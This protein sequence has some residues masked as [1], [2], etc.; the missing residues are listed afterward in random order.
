MD[1]ATLKKKLIAE[2]KNLEAEL[3]YIGDKDEQH[4]GN[5]NAKPAENDP[6]GFRDEV[7]DRL[8]EYDERLA[9]EQ[10]L[11]ARLKNVTDALERIEHG[12]YG[13]CDVCGASIEEDRILANPPARTC[14]AHLKEDR[15]GA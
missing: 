10:P 11:E 4:P 6:I 8:E 2:K 12:T 14:K 7:A 13:L 1:I 15:N 9:T 3:N 5:Y